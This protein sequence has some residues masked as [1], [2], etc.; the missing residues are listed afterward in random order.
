[1]PIQVDAVQTSPD[2]P[3][4]VDAVVIGAGII[5]TCTAYELARKGR[6]VAAGR[7]RW[8]PELAAHSTSLVLKHLK[9]NIAPYFASV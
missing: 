5:G 9:C 6:S 2:F 8:R 4:H 7:T 3:T 1:M